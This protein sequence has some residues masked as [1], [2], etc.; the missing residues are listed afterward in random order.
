MRELFNQLWFRHPPHTVLK[1]VKVRAESWETSKRS[2]RREEIVLCRLRLGHTRYTHSYLINRDPRPECDDCHC[3]LTV[4]HILVEC[5]AYADQRR[6]LTRLCQEQGT[7][8]CLKSLLGND[9]PS[10]VDAVFNYLRA[11]ELMKHL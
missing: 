5:P 10:L 4:K 3:P 11:C 1:T 2:N 8:L 6:Q 7:Q 9:Y